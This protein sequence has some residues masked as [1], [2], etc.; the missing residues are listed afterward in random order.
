MDPFLLEQ[1]QQTWKCHELLADSRRDAGLHGEAQVTVSQGLLA[2]LRQHHDTNNKSTGY[3]DFTP[4]SKAV[5]MWVRIKSD[6][7]KNTQQDKDIM[8]R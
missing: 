5:T 1:M 6:L 3:D 2:C 4:L 7:V 8:N